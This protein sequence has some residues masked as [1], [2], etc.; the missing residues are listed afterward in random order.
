M[1]NSPDFLAVIFFIIAVFYIFIGLYVFYM[2]PKLKINDIFLTLLT[3]GAIWLMGDAISINA[4]TDVIYTGWRLVSKIAGSFYFIVFFHLILTITSDGKKLKWPVMLFLLYLPGILSAFILL[5]KNFD[6]GTN[7]IQIKWGNFDLIRSYSIENCIRIYSAFY[8]IT[9]SILL[10]RWV[11]KLSDKLIRRSA[12]IAVI[13][14]IIAVFADIYIQIMFITKFG[15]SFT[16]I[17]PILFV[18]PLFIINILLYRIS[19]YSDSRKN[20]QE[21]IIGGL[22]RRAISYLVSAS[23]FIGGL[24]NIFVFY[25]LYH[26]DNI[27]LIA[28]RSILLIFSAFL[29]LLINYL[30]I[31]AQHKDLFTSL[32]TGILIP[33]IMISFSMYGAVSVWAFSFILLLPLL[34][35]RQKILMV[36]IS[37]STLLTQIIIW[38]LVPEV[39]V[40]INAG[41]YITRIL[42]FSMFVV[43]SFLL[44]RLFINRIEESKKK[45]SLQEFIAH[46]STECIG[47]NSNNFSD[48]VNGLLSEIAEYFNVDHSY[49]S[50]FNDDKTYSTIAEYFGKNI[51]AHITKE[52]MQKI[53]I[54]EK[55]WRMEKILNNEVFVSSDLSKLPEFVNYELEKHGLTDIYSQIIIPISVQEKVL[56]FWGMNTRLRTYEW[57]D[58]H[59]YF[60]KLLANILGDTLK[61]I[62]SENEIN[63]IAYYDQVTGLPN[64]TLF[65]DYL[66]FDMIKQEMTNTGLA[67]F[68]LD[69]DSFKTIND[70]VG[71]TIGDELLNS[72]GEKIKLILSKNDVVSRFSGDE[73]VMMVKGI[74]DEQDAIPIARKLMQIFYEPFILKGQSFYVTA[75]TGIAIY[76]RDGKEAGTL[77]MNADV[78]RFK[79]KE[80]G[81]NQYFICSDSIKNDAM[82]KNQIIN[83]LYRSQEREELFLQYQPQVSLEDERIIGVEALLRWD[84]PE[85]G[86]IAPDVLIPL[87]ERTGLINPIGDWILRTACQQAVEWQKKGLPEI[88]MGVNISASQFKNPN[89]V[90]DVMTVLQ[91]TGLA[92]EYLE[93]EI[94]ESIAIQEF[95]DIVTKLK[96]L[97]DQGVSIAIDDFGSEYSSLGRLKN[98]P[99][100]R[101]KMDK[102]FVDGIGTNLKDQAI[103]KAIIN[104]GKS[105]DLRIVAEGVEDENQKDF[106]KNTQCDDIQGYYYYRPLD[107][108]VLEQILR[109]EKD[110]ESW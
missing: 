85:M 28:G 62:N 96:E 98:L 18:L 91:E 7:F 61:R 109:G 105:L 53:P 50:T 67:V 17:T 100:S 31:E 37:V 60:A 39:D 16:Q 87:A 88:I 78:A 108:K 33:L 30:H 9:G 92:P 82:K 5:F 41:D 74:F 38:F 1:L 69:L 51:I 32:I 83:L 24:L 47:I 34:I 4:D 26:Q 99:I 71:H 97:G 103:A 76:P 54:D 63:R 52:E 29:I 94:T 86:R 44:N 11:V 48:R 73:F 101:L 57:S 66:Y 64:R 106:L 75:C 95:K 80:V 36:I 72:V 84:N 40:N 65:E 2:Q 14:L 90:E 55:H 70:T 77:I 13:A 22:S 10:S 56:G 107:S 110:P 21:I 19:P 25:F 42:I 15:V 93:I 79:A 58:D 68:F 6:A 59:L 89:F 35:F 23:F 45:I 49:I 81:R 104:L 8:F 12:F 46:V 20:I 3:L 27:V 43:M 102:Q